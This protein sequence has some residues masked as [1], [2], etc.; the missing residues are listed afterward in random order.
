MLSGIGLVLIRGMN[1]KKSKIEIG[2]FLVKVRRKNIEVVLKF[3]V[4]F[5]DMIL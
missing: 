1:M 2:V 5:C 3:I 4:I